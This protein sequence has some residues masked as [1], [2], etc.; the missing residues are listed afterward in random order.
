[1]S[2]A[3]HAAFSSGQALVHL[4][5]DEGKGTPSHVPAEALRR[6]CRRRVA[7]ISIREVVESGEVNAEDAH[8]RQC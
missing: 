3:V 1:M 7:M 8:R 2:L 6:Q 5:R 4:R